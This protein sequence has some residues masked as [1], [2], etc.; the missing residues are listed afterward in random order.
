MILPRSEDHELDIDERLMALARD[1]ASCALV[2]AGS[3]RAMVPG[4]RKRPHF[5]DGEFV[6]DLFENDTMVAQVTVRDLRMVPA[7]SPD[8][9][10]VGPS[11][12]PTR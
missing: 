3:F 10:R 2:S 5:H 12:Y 11:G 1:V 4:D 9:P 8:R 7:I 6:I